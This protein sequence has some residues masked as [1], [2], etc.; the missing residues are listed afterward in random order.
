MESVSSII[1]LEFIANC[2]YHH[3]E[4]VA[5]SIKLVSVDSFVKLLL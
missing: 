2:S 1:K 4:S 3:K 5:S